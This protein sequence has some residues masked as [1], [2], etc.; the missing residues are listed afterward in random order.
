MAVFTPPPLD[1]ITVLVGDV[2]HNLRQSL[3]YLAHSLAASIRNAEPPGNTSF[4][5]ALNPQQFQGSLGNIGPRRDFPDGLIDT[6]ER[7]QPY[8]GGNYILL[9]ALKQMHDRDKHRKPT[10]VAGGAVTNAAGIG[11]LHLRVVQTMQ[12]PRLG[13]I[14][15]GA[16]LMEVT[17]DIEPDTEVEMDFEFTAD[18]FFGAATPTVPAEPILEAL[19]TLRSLIVTEIAAPLEAFL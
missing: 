12:G 1:R 9:D 14:P 16:P 5:I 15:D 10:V 2:L 18:V 11:S 8:K 4:P 19:A 17:G 6:L 13:P 3:D 7:V